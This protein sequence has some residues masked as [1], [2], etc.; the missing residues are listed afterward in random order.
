MFKNVYVIPVHKNAMPDKYIN[1][2]VVATDNN[3]YKPEKVM[4]LNMSN[5]IVLTD[6]Y[7]PIDELVSTG[8]HD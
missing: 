2:M 8:Y 4:D 6:D 3:S 5:A 1:W 7:N